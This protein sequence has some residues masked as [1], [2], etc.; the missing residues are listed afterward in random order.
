VPTGRRST[1]RQAVFIL[2]QQDLLGLSAEA[3][4]GRV[5]SEE[6]GEYARALV[7]GVAE[8]REEVDGLLAE[9]VTGWSLDRLGV[10]ERAILRVAVYELLRQSEVPKAVVIDQAVGLAKRFCSEEAGALVNGILGSVAAACGMEPGAA[11]P[12]VKDGS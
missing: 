1:R 12:E 4:L 6:L 3:A 7:L 5:E 2:Y 11:L 8:N 10:L 9:H